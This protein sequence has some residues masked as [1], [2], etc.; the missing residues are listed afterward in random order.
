MFVDL[1]VEVGRGVIVG[2]GVLVVLVMAVPDAFVP[3]LL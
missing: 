3:V 2:A 1:I